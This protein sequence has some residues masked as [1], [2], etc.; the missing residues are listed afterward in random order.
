MARKLEILE[1]KLDASTDPILR[2]SLTREIATLK[3]SAA[4]SFTSVYAQAPMAITIQKNEGDKAEIMALRDKIRECD[5]KI[6]SGNLPPGTSKESYS[7]L[8]NYYNDELD[9]VMSKNK[10]N[11]DSFVDD[12]INSFSFD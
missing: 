4:D 8:K 9:R 2:D 7:T 3:R 6:D 11:I 1:K 10:G 12:R 5:Q